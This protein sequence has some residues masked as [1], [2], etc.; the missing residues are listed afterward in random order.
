MM[1]RVGPII[2]MLF[3]CG[4]AGSLP[5][6]V[7]AV[8]TAI[9]HDD[10]IY[11][12]TRVVDGDTVVLNNGE[13]VRLI[14]VDTPEYYRSRKLYADAKKLGQDAD[15][16][17]AIGEQSSHFTREMVLSKKVKLLYDRQK[18]DRYGR[19]LA[20]LFLMDGTFVNEEIIRQGYGV[21]Y[22][23]FPFRY[24]SR[25]LAAQREAMEANRGL[26]LQYRLLLGWVICHVLSYS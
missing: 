13:K 26:W 20:Y 24:K 10:E 11:T 19:V 2:A 17:K 3:L 8:A 21:A 25:F 12:V 7:R 4:C 1:R 18:R 9:H 23:R 5:G 22:T 16:I 6:V 14:G 15:E